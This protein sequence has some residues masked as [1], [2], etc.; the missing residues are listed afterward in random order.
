MAATGVTTSMPPGPMPTAGG[1]RTR[2]TYAGRAEASVSTADARRIQLGGCEQPQ[3]ARRQRQP[4]SARRRRP[5]REDKLTSSQ[6]GSMLRYLGR[7]ISGA[8]PVCFPGA[9]RGAVAAAVLLRR[10]S[11][12]RGDGDVQD[13]KF[14]GD[15]HSSQPCTARGGA[16]MPE[17]SRGRGLQRWVGCSR[18]FSC[19][20]KDKL[21]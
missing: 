3:Q 14:T 19:A 18:A 9:D 10:G 16:S 7:Y 2:E 8:Q 12:R 15:G 20:V 5:A 1:S 17:I 4:R 21:S 6:S 13:R 11:D